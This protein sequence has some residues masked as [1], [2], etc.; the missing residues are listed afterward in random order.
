MAATDG[1]RVPRHVTD[2]MYELGEV[3]YSYYLKEHDKEKER[4]QLILRKDRILIVTCL[5][6]NNGRWKDKLFFVKGVLVG[7]VTPCPSRRQRVSSYLLKS[8]IT[9]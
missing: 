8:F 4:Y 2:I 7:L 6:S 3:M 5:R 9:N 1:A